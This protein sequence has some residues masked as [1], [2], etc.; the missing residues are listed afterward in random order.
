MK[1]WITWTGV[2]EIKSYC[3]SSVSEVSSRCDT[4]RMICKVTRSAVLWRSQR[5]MKGFDLHFLWSRSSKIF[6]GTDNKGESILLASHLFSL[7][8]IDEHTEEGDQRKN[9]SSL[10]T[11][12]W[13]QTAAIGVQAAQTDEPT[14]SIQTRRLSN[15]LHW[16]KGRP[17]DGTACLLRAHF[18]I[19]FILFPSYETQLQLFH[20][21]N[22]NFSVHNVF[23]LLWHQTHPYFSCE[24]FLTSK[25]KLKHH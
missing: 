4:N 25:Q 19:S 6:I 8:A 18:N 11:R 1:L 21:K 12:S 20:H 16:F 9:S 23:I 7:L 13:C 22:Y 17:Y 14:P 15:Q 24:H 3:P 2:R 5:A 10:L